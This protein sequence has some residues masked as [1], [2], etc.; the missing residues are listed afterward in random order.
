MR[1]TYEIL[2]TR[3]YQQ[4]ISPGEMTVLHTAIYDAI[5]SG[6]PEAAQKAMMNILTYRV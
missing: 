4:G 6:R 5:L 2:L 3:Y 1:S